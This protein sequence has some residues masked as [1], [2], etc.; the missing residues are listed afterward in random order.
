MDYTASKQATG[1]IF[2]WAATEMEET[3]RHIYT[4]PWVN[5]EAHLTMVEQ[6]KRRPRGVVRVS[7][8]DRVKEWVVS[9]EGDD[10]EMAGV[11]EGQ[12]LAQG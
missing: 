4:H 1:D 5:V 10:G 2:R 6:A 3:G 11:N 12:K 9:S 7:N 8:M